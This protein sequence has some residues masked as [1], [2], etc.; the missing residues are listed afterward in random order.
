[1]L[2]SVAVSVAPLS[3][4]DMS[5]KEVEYS[6]KVYF[7][8][9]SSF[10]LIE[11]EDILIGDRLLIIDFEGNKVT[12]I[13]EVVAMSSPD[14]SKKGDPIEMRPGHVNINSNHRVDSKV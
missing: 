5:D 9:E 4:L 11:W 3:V 8:K 7:C 12:Q 2:S 1:M 14:F 10:Y 13:D 6:R